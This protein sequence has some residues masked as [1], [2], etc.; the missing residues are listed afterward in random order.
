VERTHRHRSVYKI[1]EVSLRVFDDTVIMVSKDEL[2]LWW[3]SQTSQAALK[4]ST[5]SSSS[6]SG[7]SETCP[8]A[9][10]FNGI[11]HSNSSSNSSSS[12]SGHIHI[13]Q[14]GKKTLLRKQDGSSEKYPQTKHRRQSLDSDMIPLTSDDSSSPMDSSSRSSLGY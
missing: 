13:H 10:C 11:P 9:S 1:P 3:R 5:P 7:S 8:C 6:S 2:Q 12:I 4:A 14:D